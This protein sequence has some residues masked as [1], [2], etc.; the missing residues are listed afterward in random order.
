[1]AATLVYLRIS[2]PTPEA[3]TMPEPSA[4]PVTLYWILLVVGVV[5][6]LAGFFIGQKKP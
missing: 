5:A 3:G 1:M 2:A 4:A 6:T